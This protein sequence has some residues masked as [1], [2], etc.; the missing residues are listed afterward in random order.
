M[1]GVD[2]RHVRVGAGVRR[3]NGL[4]IALVKA[5]ECPVCGGVGRMRIRAVTA[6]GAKGGLAGWIECP[7]EN[8]TS[9]ARWVAPFEN[10]EPPGGVA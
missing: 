8:P 6:T 1:R 4:V 2:P 3:M 10:V 7:L 5:G 9:I